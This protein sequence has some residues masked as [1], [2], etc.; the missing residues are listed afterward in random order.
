MDLER[1]ERIESRG[2]IGG[3]NQPFYEGIPTFFRAPYVG[4]EELSPGDIAVVGAPFDASIT[5]GRPGARYGPRAIREA[6]CHYT[7]FYYSIPNRTIVDLEN[8]TVLRIPDPLR[9]FDLGDADCYPLDIMATTRSIAVAVRSVVE[10]GVLPIVLGGDHYVAYPAFMGAAEGVAAKHPKAKIGYVHVDSHTDLFDELVSGGRFNHGTAAR[11]ISELPMVSVPHMVWIGMNGRFVSLEQYEF[12]RRNNLRIL[13]SADVNGPDGE[14]KVREALQHASNC[15]F[16][17]VSV[18][19]DVVDGSHA[20]GTGA[21]VFDGIP[22]AK[23]VWLLEEIGRI[24][25]LLAVDCCEVAP[26]FDPSG[27]TA[28]LAALAFVGLVGE[29]L[30]VREALP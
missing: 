11:R 22:A 6:S 23:L 8:H 15:D 21:A 1:E 14:E 16:L 10:K 18:D 5:V 30:F 24:D 26:Q 9:L 7:A 27:R 3:V 20:S 2:F 12:T 19:I 28:R 13:T 29:R 25:R 4:V 17:Y